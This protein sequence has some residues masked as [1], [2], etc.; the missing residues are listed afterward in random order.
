[1]TDN[2]GK[3]V[4]PGGPGMEPRWTRGAKDAGPACD[5]WALGVILDLAGLTWLFGAAALLAV[6]T[7]PLLPALTRPALF[8]TPTPAHG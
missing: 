7:V 8:P 2:Q 1:M 3:R 4:A 6:L 5:L